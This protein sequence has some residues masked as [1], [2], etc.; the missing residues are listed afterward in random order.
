MKK[1]KMMR[2]ASGLLV[3]TLLTT[4]II[5]GTFAKYVTT[6]SG[7]DNARVANWGFDKSNASIALT[8]LFKDAYDLDDQGNVVAD[9]S[10]KSETTNDDVIAPGTGNSATFKFD[11]K[12]AKK[13]PEVKYTFAVSTEGSTIADDIKN[14]DNIQWKLDNGTWGNWDTMITAIKTLSG[15]ASGSE[16]YN[17]GELPDAFKDATAASTHTVSWR[18]AFDEADKTI[19]N[20]TN[21]DETDTAM[22]NADALANVKL[23]ITVTATQID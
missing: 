20:A 5:S 3:A 6:A 21:K 7:E 11:Y 10:V 12:G 2:T 23:K 16:T 4:S 14:N 1:N 17:P 15:A 19:T 9:P 13:A 22:G 18:W 8:G